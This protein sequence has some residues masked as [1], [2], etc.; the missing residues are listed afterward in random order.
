MREADV[1]NDDAILLLATPISR[2][3]LRKKVTF[4]ICLNASF[5]VL[6]FLTEPGLITLMALH[7]VEPSFNCVM[8]RSD[9]EQM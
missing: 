8:C 6:I 5:E 4:S 1:A 7:R 2:Q 3:A 9:A